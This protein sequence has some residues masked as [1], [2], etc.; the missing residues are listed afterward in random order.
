MI[1]LSEEKSRVTEAAAD[2]ADFTALGDFI[3]SVKIT[4]VQFAS[5]K[6]INI[7]E[8]GSGGIWKAEINPLDNVA[9]FT[10]QGLRIVLARKDMKLITS[11]KDCIKFSLRSGAT[12]RAFYENK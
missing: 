12:F 1:I 3:K 6:D 11:E 10:K 4:S 8:V 5:T 2:F 9:A 7:F